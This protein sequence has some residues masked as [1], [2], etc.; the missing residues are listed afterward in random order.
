MF[1]ATWSVRLG[2]VT[3]NELTERDWENAVQGL[4]KVSAKFELR[5]ESLKSKFSLILF[6]FNLMT[7]YSKKIKKIIRESAF[8]KK[9]NRVKI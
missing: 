8:G 7:G 6:A 4:C 1:W 3:E 2:Y 5:Y 9:I